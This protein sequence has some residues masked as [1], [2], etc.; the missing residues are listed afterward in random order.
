[1]AK[2]GRHGCLMPVPPVGYP[3]PETQPGPAA[4][5]QKEKNEWYLQCRLE[6]MRRQP[7]PHIL[8]PAVRRLAQIDGTGSGAPLLLLLGLTFLDQL[9]CALHS[10]QQ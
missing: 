7:H 10:L 8:D 9:H 6:G 1:M 2:A 5:A 4:R 3:A